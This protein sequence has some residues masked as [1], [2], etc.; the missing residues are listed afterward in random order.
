MSAD[1]VVFPL[2]TPQEV[3]DRT[4]ETFRLI[5][6]ADSFVALLSRNDRCSFCRRPLKDEVSKVI[7]IGPDCAEKNGIPHNHKVAS[8]ALELRRDLL[9]SVAE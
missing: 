6:D 9:A 1:A 2:G 4:A 5:K 7:G 3:A 8:R